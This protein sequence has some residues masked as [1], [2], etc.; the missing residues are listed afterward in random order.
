MLRKDKTFGSNASSS[1]PIS[2]PTLQ[3]IDVV[4]QLHPPSTI[5]D[6]ECP[7]AEFD[8]FANIIGYE[9]ESCKCVRDAC[10]FAYRKRSIFPAVYNCF[11]LLFTAPVTVAKNERSFSEMKIIKYFL[12]STMSGE[13]LEDFVLAAE[14]DLTDKIDLEVVL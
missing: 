9:N 3:Q 12:R 11:K 1:A 4:I 10:D 2:V 5:I 7:A 8:V 14:K 6:P 13:R